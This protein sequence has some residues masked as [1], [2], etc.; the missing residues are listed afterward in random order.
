MNIYIS[1]PSIYLSILF[2]AGF[3]CVALAI[4]NFTLWSR[5]ASNSEI[6][7]PLPP[8]FLSILNGVFRNRFSDTSGTGYLLRNT[9][10]ALNL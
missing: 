3:L 4:L 5:L 6:R 10:L 1:Y 7:L 2:E 9:G 8:D